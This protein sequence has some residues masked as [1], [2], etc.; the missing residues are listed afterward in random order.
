M[1][2]RHRRQQQRLDPALATKVQSYAKKLI[3]VAQGHGKHVNDMNT[4]YQ[5]TNRSFSCMIHALL[6]ALGLPAIDVLLISE[7]NHLE[8]E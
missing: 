4:S 6:P 8:G 2:T 7:H 3:C 1:L 5:M